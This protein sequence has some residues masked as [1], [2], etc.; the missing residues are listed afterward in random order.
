MGIALSVHTLFAAIWVGGMFFAYVCLRP[1]LA[2]IDAKTRTTLWA[3]VLHRFFGY[4]FLSAALLLG[5]GLHMIRGLGSMA[6][7]GKHVHIMLGLGVVMM[8][9]ALHV[10]FAP[11][12][13]LKRAVIAGDVAEAGRRIGQIRIFVG[14]NLLLGL[15]VIVVASGGRYFFAGV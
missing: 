6:V 11:L 12:K 14:I 15:I 5:T 2:G 8:L 4:V 7:V 3:Q 9:L 1:T 10:Y 13:R